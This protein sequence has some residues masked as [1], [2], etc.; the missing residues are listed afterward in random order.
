MRPLGQIDLAERAMTSGRI[1]PGVPTSFIQIQHKNK[2][3]EEAGDKVGV[4]QRALF[5]H[6]K[7]GG[8]PVTV[9]VSEAWEGNRRWG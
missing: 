2:D 8:G 4:C 9:I 5:A 1:A 7:T 6:S 3:K